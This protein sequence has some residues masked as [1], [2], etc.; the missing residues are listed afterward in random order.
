MD[1]QKRNSYA[2]NYKYD[3]G[4]YE[5]D[6]SIDDDEEADIIYDNTEKQI[7]ASGKYFISSNEYINTNITPNESCYI[8][9]GR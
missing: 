4:A 5:V 8:V 2:I 3:L 7:T 1:Y 9:I 6:I